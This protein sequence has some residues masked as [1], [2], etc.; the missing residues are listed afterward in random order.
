MNLALR[1]LFDN[2]VLHIVDALAE[3]LLQLVLLVNFFGALCLDVP[4]GLLLLLEDFLLAQDVH[5]GASQL[6]VL[7]REACTIC[8]STHEVDALLLGHCIEIHVHSSE[9]PGIT[10]TIELHRRGLWTLQGLALLWR[11]LG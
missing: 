1:L 7:Q 4:Q 11:S 9:W 2:L 8:A 6:W 10:G 5:L 3:D